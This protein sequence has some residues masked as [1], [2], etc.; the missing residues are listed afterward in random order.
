MRQSVRE[1]LGSILIPA[2]IGLLTV[3]MSAVQLSIASYQ[4]EQEKK[5]AE[6][7][8]L[9]DIIIAQQTREQELLIVNRIRWD[10]IFSNYIH[11]VSEILRHERSMSTVDR[12]VILKI[13]SA[14]TLATCRQLDR[15][16]KN[17]VIQFLY[18]LQLIRVNQNPIDLRGLELNE[19]MLNASVKSS[20]IIRNL[21]NISLVGVFLTNASFVG[22][23]LFGSDFSFSDLQHAD[24]YFTSLENV[25]FHGSNL[26]SVNFSMTRINN[27]DLSGSDLRYTNINDEQLHK[28]YSIFDAYLPNN[29]F[30]R[31]QNFLENGDAEI[32]GSCS[33]SQIEPF[34]SNEWRS[35]PNGSIGLL[36]MESSLV[37]KFLPPW[38]KVV[39]NKKKSVLSLS[40]D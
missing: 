25:S 33:K 35:Y 8:Q 27:A 5:I 14:K 20:M 37:E 7:N 23:N 17:R 28:A 39:V 36:K 18:D 3:A 40:N 38:M 15:D 1:V 31:S 34:K 13:I 21:M 12:E 24:F 11:Q 2:M 10:S 26:S 19:I 4:R 30:G 32:F 16:A 22:R 6:E 9:K 29:T